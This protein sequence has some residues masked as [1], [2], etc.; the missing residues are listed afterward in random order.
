MKVRLAELEDVRKDP[1]AYL[2][3]KSAESPHKRMSFQRVLHLA[4]YAYHR[5][6]GDVSKAHTHLIHTFNK[7]FKQ[8]RQLDTLESQLDDYIVAYR[9][10]G[11]V[12]VETK[13]NIRI[14]ITPYVSL[15]GEIPRLD[16]VPAKGYAVWLF[17]A[18]SPSWHRELRLPLIQAHYSHL[19]GSNLEEIEIGFY[20]C[21]AAKYVS[22]TFDSLAVEASRKE[23]LALS[24]ILTSPF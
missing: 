24:G 7:N 21:V 12:A 22:A 19:L 10:S 9:T 14:D 5:N 16:V 1:V 18:P 3:R 4:I 6:Q 2:E 20:D 17:G 23:A 8:T 13:K 15:T 11:L